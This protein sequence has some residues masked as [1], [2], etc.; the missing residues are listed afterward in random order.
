MSE[1]IYESGFAKYLPQPLTHDGKMIA[2]AKA[3]EKEFLEVS[4]FIEKVLI[5][6]Q[7]DKLPEKLIDILAYDMHIDWYNYKYPLEIKR[8]LV[9]SSIKVHKKLGTKY[10]VET[11]LKNVYKTAVVE[12][13]F[14]YG[15]QPYTFR[16]KVGVGDEGLSE[17]TSR[18]IE[19]KM[20]FY[21]NLRSHCSSIFY[22]LKVERAE[23]KVAAFQKMGGKLKVK[24]FMESTLRAKT[25]R[26]LRSY[27]RS[28]LTMTIK[29]E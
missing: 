8:R 11:V 14:E 7:I 10:A 12:E 13:W 2:L 16:I 26:K 17:N 23:V 24:P 25:V 5:Y 3:G 29:K 18:E 6:S 21:K 27:Q 20:Q 22:I 19:S 9:K 1:T 4:G 15:G 28:K